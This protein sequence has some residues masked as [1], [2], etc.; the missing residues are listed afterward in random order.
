V[1]VHC[2]ASVGLV[3]VVERSLVWACEDFTSP[4]GVTTNINNTC[5][6]AHYHL[7]EIDVWCLV[8][9]GIGCPLPMST[10]SGGMKLS[11]RMGTAV[12]KPSPLWLFT[13]LYS[14][15]G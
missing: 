13:F 2:V 1:C 9:I 14:L 15:L 6:V 3:P 7:V 4:T 11:S 8:Y 5:M 10:S 12:I